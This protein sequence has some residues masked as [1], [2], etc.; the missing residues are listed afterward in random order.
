MESVFT[1][2]GAVGILLFALFKA[3]GWLANRLDESQKSAV[4]IQRMMLEECRQDRAEQAAYFQRQQ[5]ESDSRHEQSRHHHIQRIDGLQLKLET[6]LAV[7]LE[8][9]AVAH[10]RGAEA[11]A[12]N[13]EA[14]ATNSRSL[15]RLTSVVV[16]LEGHVRKTP[17]PAAPG[18]HP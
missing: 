1:Q 18:D 10:D 16:A 13:S 8:R 5:E 14:I 2:L 9:S 7:A 4:A 3:A 17:L 6:A 12:I 15:D 11:I